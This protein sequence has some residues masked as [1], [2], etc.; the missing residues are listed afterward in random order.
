MAEESSLSDIQINN[1][2]RNWI[3][4]D[5]DNVKIRDELNKLQNDGKI[6]TSVSEGRI[7]SIK[8]RLNRAIAQQKG[9]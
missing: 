7:K 5:L 1:K 3:V 4:D 6:K 2:I 9:K 8:T